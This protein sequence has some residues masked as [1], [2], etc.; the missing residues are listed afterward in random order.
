MTCS[1]HRQTPQPSRTRARSHWVLM[2]WLVDSKFKW[3]WIHLGTQGTCRK[4]MSLLLRWRSCAWW[5]FV[6]ALKSLARK[7]SL[8]DWCK[9]ECKGLDLWICS[10][11]GQR[12]LESNM[13]QYLFI[14]L[15]VETLVILIH[16][17]V[18]VWEEGRCETHVQI[19]ILI[20]TTMPPC[21]QVVVLNYMLLDPSCWMEKW[22]TP[23][24]FAIPILSFILGS[25]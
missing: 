3:T 9:K 7:I 19:D 1:Y 12:K 25:Y 8:K 14:Y 24:I 18:S 2:S 6:R 10:F 21:L 16:I 4:L 15:F 22:P 23:D 5:D 13:Y 17:L 20:N 11:L